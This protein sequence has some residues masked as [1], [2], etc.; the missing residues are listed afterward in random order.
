[1]NITWSSPYK[2]HQGST[3]KW[4]REW[5]IPN[6]MVNGFFVFWKQNRFKMLADGFNVSKSKLNGKWFLIE[7]KDDVK[8][9]KEFSTSSSAKQP[10]II[11]PE[12]NFVLPDYKLT[13]TD[14][15]RP[16]Q[17]DAA[18]R[19]VSAINHWGAAVDGSELGTGKTYSACGVAR[20]LDIPF[21]IVCPKPVIYQWEK[22]ISNHFK[23]KKCH[24]IINY[25]LLI[26]GRKDSDIASFVLS[27]ATRRN[28]FTWKLPKNSIIIWDEAHR[29]KNWKTRSSKVC[30]EAHKL[31][32]KQLFLS[33]TLA[34]SPLDLRTVG[35]CTK[36]FKTAKEYYQW[37]YD[38]GVFKGDWGLEFNN[39]PTSLKLIHKYLFEQRGERLLRDIIPNFP[40]TEIIVTAYDIN[41]ED[42][43]KI[44]EIYDEMKRELSLIKFKEKND[45]SEM[46]IRIRAL[47]K[48]EMLKIPLIEEMVRDGNETGMSVIIFLNF[49]DSIDAL[50]KRLNTTCIYDGRNEKVRQKCLEDFQ[51]NKEIVLI[52]NLAAA[53][54]GLNA[55]DEHGGH[56]RLALISP[57]DS[58]QKLKQ[59]FGRVH[60]ENS[61]TKSIQRLI[62]VANTQEENVVD[63]VGQKLENMT[64]INNGIITDDDLKI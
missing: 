29:L 52:T 62:Y 26:R 50:A 58:V 17:V 38:H 5:A 12:N 33:A 31:G 54:E 59:V 40:E 19:L 47:Q 56:P 55:G 45:E 44:R 16:W 36:M 27:R 57:N 14:G 18:G 64:L 10:S 3:I 43:N 20:E 37:A 60:R 24:G 30:M 53:R 4:K 2:V 7:T 11:T 34:A 42:T 21:V 25:E 9:F 22:V 32:Y 8:L 49:S 15:L 61:K 1:M 13:I 51:S 48:T 28:K 41:E 23:L 35:I 6:D 63:N 46:A 39:S